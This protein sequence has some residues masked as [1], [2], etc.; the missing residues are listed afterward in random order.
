MFPLYGIQGYNSHQSL[1]TERT[2]F[3]GHSGTPE[4]GGLG[5]GST[6]SGSSQTKNS[7]LVPGQLYPVNVIH[8][9]DASAV[10][11]RSAIPEAELPPAYSNIQNTPPRVH[12]KYKYSI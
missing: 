4:S 9:D 8:T 6:S 12:T 11:E 2:T 7:S 3:L 5:R 10:N 1:Q